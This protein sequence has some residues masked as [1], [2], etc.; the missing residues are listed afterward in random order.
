MILSLQL[1]SSQKAVINYQ[2]ETVLLDKEKTIDVAKIILNEER[3]SRKID[4]LRVELGSLSDSLEMVA[5]R[6]QKSLKRIQELQDQ[7]TGSFQKVQDLTNEQLEIEKKKKA[8]GLYA[9]TNISGNREELSGVF[10]GLALA[11]RRTLITFTV[12]PFQ[13]GPIILQAG[14]G[15]K[16][17]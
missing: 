7:L 12:D 14:L 1:A 3:L 11:R 15:L 8:W 17:F 2:N 16:I 9:Y 5:I 6:Y 13:G 10:G 4:S